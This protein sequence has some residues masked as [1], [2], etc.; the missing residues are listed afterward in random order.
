MPRTFSRGKKITAFTLYDFLDRFT[1]AAQNDRFVQEAKI[2]YCVLPGLD[3]QDIF[4][5][6]DF[7]KQA[8]DLLDGLISHNDF[9]HEGDPGFSA[10]LHEDVFIRPAKGLIIR[11]ET[12]VR[13]G[14]LV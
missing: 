14:V 10:A 12:K 7:L 11:I 6:I 13:G 8:R 3:E 2:R 4:E 9:F 5:I 1:T